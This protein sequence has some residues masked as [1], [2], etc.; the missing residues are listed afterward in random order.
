MNR[1]NS[2]RRPGTPRHDQDRLVSPRR[3]R[4]R[5]AGVHEAGPVV[6]EAAEEGWRMPC[7]T[8]LRE[9]LCAM[10][11]EA[12]CLDRALRRTWYLLGGLVLPCAG[13]IVYSLAWLR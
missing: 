5:P 1:S 6:P 3:T 7:T 13:L 11:S 4:L 9:R 12:E 8:L 2:L 10:E